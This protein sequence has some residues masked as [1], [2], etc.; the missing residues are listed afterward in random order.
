MNQRLESMRAAHVKLSMSAD[1]ALIWH[2]LGHS[3]ASLA[4]GRFI[5]VRLLPDDEN[6]G[7]QTYFRREDLKVEGDLFIASMGAAAQLVYTTSY[8]SQEPSNVFLDR[9]IWGPAR[10]DYVNLQKNWS[11]LGI[12]EDHFF[13]LVHA[14]HLRLAQ[15]NDLSR[16]MGDWAEHL[17]KKQ[18]LLPADFDPLPPGLADLWQAAQQYINQS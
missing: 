3:L 12:S 14:L 7:G 1:H 2:E 4:L 16:R 18:E 9:Y 13:S 5:A 10:G 11:S 8:A 6:I 17:L 15:T